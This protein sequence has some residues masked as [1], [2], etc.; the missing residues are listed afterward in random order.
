MYIMP[1]RGRSHL[2]PRF[3]SVVPPQPETKGLI[4]ID[5]D[6]TDSYHGMQFPTAWDVHVSPRTYITKK[7]NE[8]FAMYPNE[9]FYGFIMDDTVPLTAR[10]DVLLAEKAGPWGVAWSDDC[11]PGKRPS[12]FAMGGELV[13]ALGWIF[14]PETKHFYTDSVWEKIAE[15]LGCAGRCEEIKVAHLHFS[16]G[17]A[18]FDKTY[19]E[20]PDNA[21][22]A[23]GFEKWLLEWPEI[24]ARL[25]SL[26]PLIQETV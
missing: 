8:V 24:K 7:V 19:A 12:A 17:S 14:C 4:T 11:L 1:T 15:D 5:E 6:D 3:F 22:D 21:T 26:N 23:A 2:I 13:R 10:W 9:P 16:N 20:R 18:P 25:K